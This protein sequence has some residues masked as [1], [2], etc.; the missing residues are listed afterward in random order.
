MRFAWDGG[1]SG[2]NWVSTYDDNGLPDGFTELEILYNGTSIY[3]G[4][5]MIG[6]GNRVDPINP[7]TAHL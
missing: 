5:V 2:T 7:G 1:E 6:E 4:G 3:R